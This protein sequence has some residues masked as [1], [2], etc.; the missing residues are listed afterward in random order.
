NT[1]TGEAE[2]N[3]IAA[4]KKAVQ[5]EDQALDAQV[6]TN[7]VDKEI[8]SG[9][10]AEDRAAKQQPGAISPATEAWEK[11]LNA[12][13]RA[14]LEADPEP[15][16][17]WR[18]MDPDVRRALTYCSTPCIPVNVH[19]WPEVL[20]QI[21]NLQQQL[22]TPP[23]HRG[24]REYL[25]IYRND[26]QELSKAIKALDSINNLNEFEAFLDNELIKLIKK[27]QGVTVRKGTDG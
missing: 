18:D 9:Q 16:K 25:H 6:K 19:E 4:E 15:R 3:P 22:K 8:K 21:K 7:N 13:T 20:A 1:A 27:T 12:E 24:W 2:T 23:E 5:A 11:S 10:T 17:F 26:R 14:L